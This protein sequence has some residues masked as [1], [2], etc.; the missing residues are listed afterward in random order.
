MKPALLLLL[1]ALAPPAAARSL[2]PAVVQQQKP[3]DAVAQL[4]R[5]WMELSA[6]KPDASGVAKSRAEGRDAILKRAQ[7]LMKAD[8][9]G[10]IAVRVRAWMVTAGVDP[11]NQKAYFD[12]IVAK[13]LASP[14]LAELPDDLR[15]QSRSDARAMLETLYQK[16]QDHTV[17]GRA[18][19]MLGEH[20]KR[21]LDRVRA[22][23]AGEVDL[24]AL[25]KDFGPERAAQM[26][27]SSVA[28]LEKEYVAILEGVVK[29]YADVKDGRERTI[30]ARAEGALFELRRLQ[31]G[32]IAPD[33]EAE[34][35]D[36]VTFKL[37]DYRGKVIVLDFWGHW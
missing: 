17:R 26:Q 27:K 9:R 5:D 20:A 24:D 8:P 34:D 31:I 28:G 16:A 11:E 21:D 7:E 2:D 13:D 18:L 19:R 35:V 33:I 6:S 29:D 12:E 30:G 25:E 32:M 23:E 22:L 37:S 10:V 36:G 3:L 1:L 15:P 4:R 14:G